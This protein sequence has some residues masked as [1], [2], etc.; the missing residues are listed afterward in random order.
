MLNALVLAAAIDVA[1][2]CAKVE[3][4]K[5]P[6]VAQEDY[7]ICAGDGYCLVD[8]A[9]TFANGNGV[10]RDY[11][12]ATFLLCRA[13]DGIAPAESEGM[14]EHI[15][16]MRSGETDEPFVLCEHI[17]SGIGQSRCASISYSERMPE[18]E[19]RRDAM[20]AAS[21][22]PRLF[23]ALDQAAQTYRDAEVERVGELSRGGTAHAALVTEAE[24]DEMQ[25]YVDALTAWTTRR[26]AAATAA[27]LATA[28]KALN[29]NYRAEIAAWAEFSDEPGRYEGLCRDAQRAWIKYRDAFAAFYVA[30]WKGSASDEVLRREIVTELTRT[31]ARELGDE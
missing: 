18:L 11:D 17:T 3:R 10:P 2:I 8:I 21:A 22:T 13:A 20:R 29:T 25:H 14:I 4:V 5:V 23:G 7:D 19:A 28:D 26:A 27:E 15:E 1:Q 9:E 6:A 12:V 24:M 30:K 16:A 31:R